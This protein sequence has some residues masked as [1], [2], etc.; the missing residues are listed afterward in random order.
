VRI[1]R[2]IDAANK[3]TN[4]KTEL[5]AQASSKITG[6]DFNQYNHQ[7]LAT[8]ITQII[9]FYHRIKFSIFANFFILMTINIL[10]CSILYHRGMRPAGVILFLVFGTLISSAI[11][12]A[13]GIRQPAEK[14]VNQCG[15]LV[16][17]MLEYISETKGDISSQLAKQ[18]KNP[19]FFFHLIKGFA[20]V[21]LIPATHRVIEGNMKL[22]N[23][24]AKIITQQAI[25][26]FTRLLGVSIMTDSKMYLENNKKGE[27]ILDHMVKSLIEKIPL[28][29]ESISKKILIPT[30]ILIYASLLMGIPLLALIYFLFSNPGF[31]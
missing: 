13:R 19:Q 15:C 8:R 7:E 29:N 23:R 12:T 1:Y 18:K 14:A 4:S 20:L 21:V 31:S 30:N 16:S 6:I 28:L 22:W 9:N 25:N 10:L 17:Y 3:M 24:P 2:K 11:G 5:L 27:E 26:S